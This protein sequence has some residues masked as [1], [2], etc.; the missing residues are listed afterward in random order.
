MAR[1]EFT[2][3]MV[4][5]DLH[6]DK[7]CKRVANAALA[8]SRDY[9]SK[10]RILA[11]DIWDFRAWRKGADE[12]E[13][14]ERVRI[15]FEAGMRFVE[16][17]RPTHITLGNHDVRLWDQRE[18][19]NGPMACYA[20]ELIEQFDAL[21]RKLKTKVL[22][23]DKSKGILRIGKLKVAHGFFDGQ[24]AARQMAQAYG[25]ILFGHGHAIDVASSPSDERRAARMIGCLCQLRFQYNRT[26]VG[27][28]RQAHGWAYGVMLPNGT[29]H[30]F[31]VEIIGN[32]MVVADGF[33]RVRI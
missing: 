17:Y 8:F 20:G 2:P 7:Q 5:S 25:S 16:E 18:R 21:T 1:N 29:Y 12:E 11:G 15:D 9:K 32:E 3:F 14:R 26:H 4:C 28:L 19:G 13:K 33:R 10:I 31:Q 30:A 27:S 24:N 22:P 6:G 23:Y